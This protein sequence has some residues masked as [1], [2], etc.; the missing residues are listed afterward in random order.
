MP[1]DYKKQNGKKGGEISARNF[2]EGVKARKF[3]TPKKAYHQTI[4][5]V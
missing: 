1:F 4:H 2:K 5:Q 3:S